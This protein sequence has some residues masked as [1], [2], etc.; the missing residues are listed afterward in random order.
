VETFPLFLALLTVYLFLGLADYFTTLAV[1][2]SGEG[3]EVNPIMAPLVAAGEPA[4][5]AQLASGAL[6]AAFYLVDPGEA[7]VGLLIV[8][9]LKALVVVN[10]SINAYL[11]VLKL[12]K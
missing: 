8:T 11:V 7:L 9:V 6:S 2:E 12:R 10:N 4:L 5:W 3:R 1:V